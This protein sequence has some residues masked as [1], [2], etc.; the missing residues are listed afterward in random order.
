M[1]A[2]QK[3]SFPAEHKDPQVLQHIKITHARE[4]LAEAQVL[5]HLV[6]TGTGIVSP[7][8]SKAMELCQGFRLTERQM[9]DM[10]AQYQL[11]VQFQGPSDGPV[12]TQHKVTGLARTMLLGKGVGF[13]VFDREDEGDEAINTGKYKGVFHAVGFHDGGHYSIGI[14][15]IAKIA[16][17]RGES[18]EE[19]R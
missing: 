18:V 5:K 10:Y 14:C 9:K 3:A 7:A 12:V 1:S 2:V 17:E 11:R 13:A 8:F 19:V 16:E 15:D 6:V 4:P